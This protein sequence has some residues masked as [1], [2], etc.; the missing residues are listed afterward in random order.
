MEFNWKTTNKKLQKEFT[1]QNFVECIEFVNR[2]VPLAEQLDHH[3]DILIYS[4]KRVKIILFTHSEGK[5]TKLDYE[6]AEQ[7]DELRENFEH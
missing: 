5:L 1:F 7:I 3:P 6:L 2:I 4:Y